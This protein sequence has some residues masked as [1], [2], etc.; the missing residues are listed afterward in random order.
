[1]KA[2]MTELIQSAI[3]DSGLPLLKIA[4]LAGIDQGQLSRFMRNE[5]QLTLPVVEQLCDVLGLE[6]KATG[7]KPKKRNGDPDMNEISRAEE[8]FANDE[9]AIAILTDG[10]GLNIAGGTSCCWIVNRSRIAKAKTVILYRRPTG[11]LR[12]DVYRADFDRAVPSSREPDRD[13]VHFNNATLVG[14]TDENWKHFAT[15]GQWPIRYFNI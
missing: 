13:V 4:W 9:P 3:R 2:N 12:A 15:T 8:L 7:K 5:R 11:T 6:L 10:R 14:W 1:M